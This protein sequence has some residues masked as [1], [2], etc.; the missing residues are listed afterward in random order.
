[1]SA[2]GRTGGSWAQQYHRNQQTLIDGLDLTEQ[3][4]LFL[5]YRWLDEIDWIDRD[6]VRNLRLHQLLRVLAIVGGAAITGLVGYGVGSQTSDETKLVTLVLSLVVTASIAL[7]EFFRFGD[8]WRHERVV[9]ETMRSEGALFIALAGPYGGLT[10]AVAFP[11]FAASIERLAR[12]DVKRWVTAA[13][14]GGGSA[15]E[16]SGD[17]G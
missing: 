13:V 14:T 11:M 7:D 4:K 9:V 3:Q 8:R 1:M 12:D 17:G 6:A 5:E 10:H 15:A 16:R 2:A